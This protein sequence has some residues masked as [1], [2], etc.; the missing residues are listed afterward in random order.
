MGRWGGNMRTPEP[1]SSGAEVLWSHQLQSVPVLNSLSKQG[2]GW[3][4]TWCTLMQMPCWIE[5]WWCSRWKLNAPRTSIFVDIFLA[6]YFGNMKKPESFWRCDSRA[7]LEVIFCFIQ[8]KKLIKEEFEALFNCQLLTAFSAVLDLCCDFRRTSPGLCR[9]FHVLSNPRF[10]FAYVLAWNVKEESLDARY[11][12]GTFH[13]QCWNTAHPR[14]SKF[15]QKLWGRLPSE[16]VSVLHC[17]ELASRH[18]LVNSRAICI[19]P[20]AYC[21]SLQDLLLKVNAMED[22]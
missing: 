22:A 1:E 11:E 2:C 17:I 6:S 13:N 12:N 7:I 8:K 20:S 21:S 16:E 5:L 3:G 4:S 18:V 15:P 14:C 9:M 19:L 10:R